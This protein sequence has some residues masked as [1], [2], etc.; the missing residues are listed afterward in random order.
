MEVIRDEEMHGLMMIPLFTQYGIHR[1][2]VR[3][4]TEKPTSIILNIREDC[5][6]FALCETHFQECHT[7]NKI[8]YTLDFD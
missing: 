5:P 1:C 3:E 2:N 8:N 7:T 6:I 4:C